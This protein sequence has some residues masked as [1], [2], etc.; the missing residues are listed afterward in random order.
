MLEMQNKWLVGTIMSLSVS[1]ATLNCSLVNVTPS[2]DLQTHQTISYLNNCVSILANAI[3]I[4][5][6]SPS[7]SWCGTQRVY[8]SS[9]PIVYNM[10]VSVCL[11]SLHIVCISMSVYMYQK[12]CTIGMYHNLCTICVYQYVSSCVW[13]SSAFPVCGVFRNQG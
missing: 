5:F 8:L 12:L 13:L 11:S 9:M 2:S 3:H 1:A 4:L 7:C 6:L 10:Y